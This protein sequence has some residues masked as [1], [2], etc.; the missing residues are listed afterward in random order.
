MAVVNGVTVAIEHSVL[1][2]TWTLGNADT[3]TTE[4]LARWPIKAIEFTGAFGG[5][6]VVLEGSEDGVTFFTLIAESTATPNPGG[7][8]T[9]GDVAVSTLVVARFG[10]ITDNPR[11]IRPRSSGG[12]GTAVVATLTS[13]QF[14]H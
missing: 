12:A 4:E 1:Q 13:R 7:T 10:G 5:A 14:G 3:G 9:P 11:F 6:T 8:V 2:T